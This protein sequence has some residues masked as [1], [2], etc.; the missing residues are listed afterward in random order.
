MLKGLQEATNFDQ[1]RDD[2]D[3]KVKSRQNVIRTQFEQL[4]GAIADEESKRAEAMNLV[5]GFV[6]AAIGAPDWADAAGWTGPWG[7]LGMAAIIFVLMF[8][9]VWVVQRLFAWK[10]GGSAR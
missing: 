2:F 6:A 10:R 1:L 4:S 3:S 7:N 5:L 9:V 8:A